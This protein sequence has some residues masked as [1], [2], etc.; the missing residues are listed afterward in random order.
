MDEPEFYIGRLAETG[1]LVVFQKVPDLEDPSFPAA[2]FIMG[3]D[4]PVL[5]PTEILAGPWESEE[6]FCKWI[7]ERE[8]P[9]E[10]VMKKGADDDIL[11][12]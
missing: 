8:P 1:E 10:G 5:E 3:W 11:D 6:A 4:A 9:R 12:Q 2:W 7:L